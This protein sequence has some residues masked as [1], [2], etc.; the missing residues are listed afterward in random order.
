MTT[1]QRPRPPRQAPPTGPNPASRGLILVVAAVLIGAILLIKGPGIGFETDSSDVE[2]GSG[3]DEAASTETTVTSST[4]PGTSVPS[5]ALQ[6]VV[7]NGAG[8]NGYAAAAASFLNVAG[9]PNVAAETAGAQVQTTTVYFA[10]GFEG[11]AQ[12]IATA[13]SVGTVSPLPAEQLGK[14]AEDVPATANVV[15]V[16]GPDV[17]GIISP[18]EGTTTT[19]PAEGSSG[20]TIPASGGQTTSTAG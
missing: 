19:A 2:I 3:G 18:T 20:S 8:I 15:V 1:T 12:A 14:A 5:S 6:V 16:V 11:D 7:L 9:Y 10:P 17:Q 13:L 4:V